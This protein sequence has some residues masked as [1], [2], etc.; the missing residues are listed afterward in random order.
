MTEEVNIGPIGPADNLLMMPGLE[1]APIAPAHAI[2]ALALNFAMKYCDITTVQEGAL[3][4]QFKLEGRNMHDLSLGEVFHYAKQI[5]MHLM[6]SS[7][8]IAAMLIDAI[9][10]GIDE[11]GL[12]EGGADAPSDVSQEAGS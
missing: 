10:H 4:Q 5:E 6:A 1:N 7:E 9:A 3:Y 12:G 11:E 2:A 8:R